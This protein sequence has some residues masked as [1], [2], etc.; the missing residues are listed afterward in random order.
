MTIDLGA[1]EKLWSLVRGEYDSEES[2]RRA[3]RN[4]IRFLEARGIDATQSK[5]FTADSGLSYD[6]RV[7]E[8]YFEDINGSKH[9]RG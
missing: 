4:I 1:A 5:V 3:A 8:Y 6:R 2:K 9:Y 7:N